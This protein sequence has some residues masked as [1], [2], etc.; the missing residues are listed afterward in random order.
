MD[1]SYEYARE[2]YNV[3]TASCHTRGCACNTLQR[4]ATYC[5]TYDSGWWTC[6]MTEHLTYITSLTCRVTHVDA[7][8]TH[9]NTLQQARLRL[10]HMLH[11]Y[12]RETCNVVN[13]S[14]SWMRLQR[15]ATRCQTL[16]HTATHCSMHDSDAWTC[17]MTTHIKYIT[18][19]IRRVTHVDAPATHC[20]TLQHTATRMTQVDGHVR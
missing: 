20:N 14:H 16:Q 10:M 5:N 13:K 15:T 19:L 3:V 2:M 4:S 9:C 7:P 8:A 12:T 17:Q 1:T 6:P 11:H 18:S